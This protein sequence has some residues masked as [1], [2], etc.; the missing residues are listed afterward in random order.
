M[1]G[2]LLYAEAV[3]ESDSGPGQVRTGG[4]QGLAGRGGR[5]REEKGEAEEEEEEEEKNEDMAIRM[6]V[7]VRVY[8]LYYRGMEVV[9]LYGIIG[10]TVGDYYCRPVRRKIVILPHVRKSE[11][12]RSTL[13]L[14]SATNK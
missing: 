5:E 10:V 2:R 11:P 14:D 9:S 4:A 3:G 6:E 7:Y 1:R 12:R 13:D 8:V